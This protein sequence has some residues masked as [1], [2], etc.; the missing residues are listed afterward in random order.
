MKTETIKLCQ[1]RHRRY[2]SRN[3]TEKGEKK[4]KGKINAVK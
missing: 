4:A 3:A 2:N 1:V